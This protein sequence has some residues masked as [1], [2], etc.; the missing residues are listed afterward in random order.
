MAR[1]L[2][3]AGFALGASAGIAASLQAAGLRVE[4]VLKLHE[5]RPNIEEAIGSGEI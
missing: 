4:T 5:S 2:V 1:R 3:Q